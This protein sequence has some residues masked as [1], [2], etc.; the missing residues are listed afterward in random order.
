MLRERWRSH[1][2]ASAIS[3]HCTGVTGQSTRNDSAALIG[4]IDP[5]SDNTVVLRSDSIATTAAAITQCRSAHT[6]SGSTHTVL[7][8]CV[9]PSLWPT[10]AATLP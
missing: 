3:S 7:T 4:G 9:S 10:L 6:A 8:F 2:Q 1:A 5:A